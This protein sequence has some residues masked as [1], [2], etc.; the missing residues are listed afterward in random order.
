MVTRLP[1]NVNITFIEAHTKHLVEV[2][3]AVAGDP[4][5][6]VLVGH[7]IHIFANFVPY[8]FHWKNPE[9]GIN[10]RSS[11]QPDVVKQSFKDACV[12]ATNTAIEAGL[13]DTINT[14]LCTTYAHSEWKIKCLSADILGALVFNN[15]QT[16]KCFWSNSQ[17]MNTIRLALGWPSSETT[18]I[19]TISQTKPMISLPTD[20]HN[21]FPTRSSSSFQVNPKL[22]S[23]TKSTVS[24]KITPQQF[25]G[26]S[27]TPIDEEVD[28]RITLF[29]VLVSARSPNKD[30][31]ALLEVFGLLDS[32][33]DTILW[34][35]QTI[36]K[37]TVHPPDQ[38]G[39][40]RRTAPLPPQPCY[41]EYAEELATEQNY[42][43]LM[44]TS[45]EYPLFASLI[46][47][48]S[49][50]LDSVGSPDYNIFHLFAHTFDPTFRASLENTKTRARFSEN[51]IA[52][53]YFLEQ[54]ICHAHN[55][56]SLD[57]LPPIK[58]A[59]RALF[60]SWF[61]GRWDVK[62]RRMIA[63]TFC[64]L[65]RCVP[66]PEMYIPLFDYITDYIVHGKGESCTFCIESIVILIAAYA[67]DMPTSGISSGLVE[68]LDYSR[69]IVSKWWSEA[70]HDDSRCQCAYKGYAI[71]AKRVLGS[72]CGFAGITE[73]INGYYLLFNFIRDPEFF[74]VGHDTVFN[75]F[76]AQ[77]TQ[78]HILSELCNK[79]VDILNTDNA[80]SETK[81][82]I[83][84]TLKGIRD[85]CRLSQ[86][87]AGLFMETPLLTYILD[88]GE[89]IYREGP[90][91]KDA[92]LVVS[93]LLR[94]LFCLLENVKRNI[95]HS[96]EEHS[97]YMKLTLFI[98]KFL[99]YE[100]AAGSTEYEAEVMGYLFNFMCNDGSPT[101]SLLPQLPKITPTKS[102]LMTKPSTPKLGPVSSTSSSLLTLPTSSSSA[103]LTVG[104]KI[105]GIPDIVNPLILIEILNL[106]P[107]LGSSEAVTFV[108]YKLSHTLQSP[109]NKAICC[110]RS[111]DIIRRLLILICKWDQTIIN[112]RANET[113]RYNDDNKLIFEWDPSY[114]GMKFDPLIT[115]K[116]VG[117]IQTLGCHNL[118][119]K[120]LHFMLRILACSDP[121]TKSRLQVFPYLIDALRAIASG[122]I[123]G[124]CKTLLSTSQ[125]QLQQNTAEPRSYYEF[126]QGK[127]SVAAA[128]AGGE[129]GSGIILPPTDKNLYQKGFTFTGWVRIDRC[130]IGEYK[131]RIFGLF[132]ENEVGIEL[133]LSDSF[134]T[135]RIASQNEDESFSFS[136][137]VVTERRWM[138]LSLTISTSLLKSS[139]I[140]L[141]IDGALVERTH[142]SYPRLPPCTKNSI[143]CALFTKED[144]FMPTQCF[145]GQIASANF[146]DEA[147]TQV[148][149]QQIYGV[150]PNYIG[151]FTEAE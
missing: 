21:L 12:C 66:P 19:D 121:K 74:D 34:G 93:D 56:C 54:I 26:S 31:K 97:G 151:L 51:S 123:I 150:G 29:R 119:P 47:H 22:V 41:A 49:I 135:F 11:T 126:T 146:F 36:V 127:V 20:S 15:E 80:L 100:K 33:V 112:D 145:S 141:Y 40:S 16:G 77:K 57:E 55:K 68:I 140:R 95:V 106:L 65:A 86:E 108:L 90:S 138:F 27:S 23:S 38:L 64:A 104:P 24:M 76:R 60:T 67:A 52:Q 70:A 114:A 91:A 109:R 5:L 14:I 136:K 143:G 50:V 72:P 75:L 48:I 9:T 10:L 78:V 71:Q 103:S 115:P 84:G 28:F 113:N 82:S 39:S 53:H 89:L 85:I 125:P 13:F 17:L 98:K 134:L 94:T 117:V 69:K 96:F 137:F 87:H 118:A 18:Y 149:I 111:L 142:I 139:E 63:R 25:L 110:H 46:E 3:T 148:Q 2:F 133:Y 37:P 132:G 4:T 131:P 92:F 105:F 122:S 81:E 7:C 58:V 79:Y 44:K 147:L 124:S 73:G 62:L 43:S 8:Q 32:A 30:I 101:S 6:V 120:D 107:D 130:G 128:T 99:A 42:D 35:F 102:T 1:E 83:S 129:T 144:I 88:R 116:I 45:K 59:A 61:V